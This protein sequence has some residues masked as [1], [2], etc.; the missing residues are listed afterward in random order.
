MSWEIFKNNILSVANNPDQ[1]NSI[2]QV[3]ELYAREYDAAI[4]RGRDSVHGISL[5]QGNVEAMKQFFIVALQKGLNSTE[6]YDLVGEMGKGVLAYWS[7]GTMANFPIPIIPAVGAVSNI[8][9][10]SNTVTTVGVWTPPQPSQPNFKLSEE[11]IAGAKEDLT[12]AEEDLIT[13]EE[14]GD[15]EAVQT[16]KEQIILQENRIADEEDYST[17]DDDDRTFGLQTEIPLEGGVTNTF[18]LLSEQNQEEI[19]AD[20]N[21]G[22]RIVAFASKDVGTLEN[23]LPPGKPENWGQRVSEMLKGVGF[24]TPAYWCAAAVASWYRSAGAKSPNSASCDV[25]MAWAK[26]NG[27]FSRTPV[28]G[29]AVLYG[30]SADAHH[31]GIVESII[32]NKIRTIEGNTSGGGFNRNGVGVFRKT[33]NINK[34]VGFVLPVKK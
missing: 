29:A 13:F 25:W 6:P 17:D 31:I 15:D 32:N 1:I 34:V 27:L 10:I 19:L 2:E 33:A 7:G 5:Q 18:E 14:A 3:A 23:P 30:S 8:G 12:A 16:A 20:D 21:I 26:R 11:Q 24:K 22:R 9:V 28:V 4:K